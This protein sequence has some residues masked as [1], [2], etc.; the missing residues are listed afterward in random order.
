MP[1]KAGVG[2]AINFAGVIDVQ[3][4]A[5]AG[6]INGK[7]AAIG[8]DV[9]GLLDLDFRVDV[10]YLYLLD[11]IGIIFYDVIPFIKIIK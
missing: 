3:A 4:D 5:N 2:I 8:D 1:A 10:L 11:Q 9:E 7:C 6:W